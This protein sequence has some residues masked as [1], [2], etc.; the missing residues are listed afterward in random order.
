[1]GLH[2]DKHFRPAAKHLGVIALDHIDDK[3]I[4]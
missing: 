2:H 3:A 1:M 4:T